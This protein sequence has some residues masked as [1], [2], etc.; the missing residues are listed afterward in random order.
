M[1]FIVL[2]EVP[3]TNTTTEIFYDLDSITPFRCGQPFGGSKES[4]SIPRDPYT[5]TIHVTFVSHSSFSFY[6]Q[7]GYDVF[8]VRSLDPL[9]YDLA[10]HLASDS[11]SAS[12]T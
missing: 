10:G 1:L 4:Y 8:R 2:R 7:L 12:K 5:Y 3:K 9:N 6:V 11:L